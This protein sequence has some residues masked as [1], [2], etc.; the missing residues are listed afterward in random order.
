[1]LRIPFVDAR[2]VSRFALSLIA[3]C[4][5]VLSPGALEPVF[6]TE[7]ISANGK[8]PIN[9]LFGLPQPRTLLQIP[10]KDGKTATR[11][12]FS[13][14]HSNI[15]SGGRRGG[16]RLLMDGETTR[17]SLFLSRR[18]SGCFAA[19]IDVPLVTHTPGRLDDFIETWHDWFNLP[20]AKRSRREQNQLELAYTNTNGD[21]PRELQ[22]ETQQQGVGDVAAFVDVGVGCL[23]PGRQAG[24]GSRLHRDRASLRLGIKFP[25]GH[26]TRLTGSE[27]TD[28]SIEYTAAAKRRRL[29]QRQSL[30]WRFRT[31]IFAPGESSF[32]DHQE[33]VVIFGSGVLD[34]RLN[35]PSGSGS[36]GTIS[37]AQGLSLKLQIDAH[38]P[39]FDSRLTELGRWTAQLATG[40]AWQQ[41][42]KRQWQLSLLED[43]V[44]DTTPDFVVYLGFSQSL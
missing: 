38:S 44:I 25:T 35:S 34:W 32:F 18:F 10:A 12:D 27:T 22:I 40:I 42:Q 2:I 33:S 6:A 24:P 8:H 31:G 20:D 14:A 15:F 13:I 4:L 37:G 21:N 3:C 11:F 1:M 26:L 9:G 7:F 36:S 5:C 17:T 28:L 41:D 30:S 29:G 39:M 16:E 23:I 43:V 19:G